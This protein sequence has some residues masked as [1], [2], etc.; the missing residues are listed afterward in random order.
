MNTAAAIS[1]ACG[2][3]VVSDPRLREQDFARFEGMTVDE[4]LAIYPEEYAQHRLRTPDTAVHGGES[5]A[6]VRERIA[7]FI[8]D[9]E[10]RH[11]GE[12]VVIVSHGGAMSVVLWHLLGIPY[13]AV[14]RTRVSNT[15]LGGFIREQDRWILECWN[16]TGHLDSL[17]DS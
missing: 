14:K 16:D 10:D 1:A 2:H 13:E 17:L 5:S 6:Q 12:T 3:C 9:I 4:L 11:R 7:A 8:N 15:G